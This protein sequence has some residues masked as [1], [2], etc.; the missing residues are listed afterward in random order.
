MA[1]FLNQI[2]RDELPV[3]VEFRSTITTYGRSA[4]GAQ[5]LSPR[6]TRRSAT[7]R[8]RPS[9]ERPVERIPLSICLIARELRDEEI[10]EGSGRGLRRLAGRKYSVQ[11]D[12]SHV[13]ICENPDEGPLGELSLGGADP[14]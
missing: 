1:R 9:A 7:C 5:P 14:H 10:D 11:L 12:L 3:K 6:R 2:G 4:I 8:K 13:P